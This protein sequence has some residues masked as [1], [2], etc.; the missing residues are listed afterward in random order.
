MI[1]K[2]LI[3][4]LV[5]TVSIL[6][7]QQASALAKVGVKDKN[8]NNNVNKTLDQVARTFLDINNI[9]TQFYNNG[10]GDID[11]SG[12]AGCVYPKGS[13]KTCVFTSGLLWGGLVKGEIGRASCR[14]RV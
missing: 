14:E 6:L 1:S 7:L 3:Y 2:K 11:P 5:F 9:S 10:I 12:N 8:Q 4:L 13:G